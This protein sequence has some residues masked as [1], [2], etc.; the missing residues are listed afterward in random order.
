ML[1]TPRKS[2]NARTI[3]AITNQPMQNIVTAGKQNRS[4]LMPYKKGVQVIYGIPYTIEEQRATMTLNAIQNKI[5]ELCRDQHRN[6][7]LSEIEQI[8]RFKSVDGMQ[9]PD[10]NDLISYS[11]LMSP[12]IGNHQ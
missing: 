9:L 4:P 6:P 1:N 12:K 2:S 10:A 8:K 7:D 3:S 5:I 11:V